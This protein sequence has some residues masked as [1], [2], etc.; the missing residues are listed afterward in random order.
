[1][2]HGV[3]EALTYRGRGVRRAAPLQ[4]L[5]LVFGT[6]FGGFGNLDQALP[7]VGAAVQDD[8]FHPFPQHGLH[9]VV[10][11]HHASVDDT[12]VHAR[13][14][15]VV[16]KH[17]V[18]GLA[19][20]VVAAKRKAHVRHATRHLGT[21]QVLLDPARGLDEVHRV[22]VVLLNAS[23]DGEDV[24]VE[25]DVFSREPHFVNQNAVSALADGDLALVGVGLALLVKG[26][27]HGGGTVAAHQSGLALELG[28]AFFHADGVDD[29]FALHTA[30]AGLDD[31]PLAGV[32][33]DRNPRNIWLGRYQIEKAHHGGLAVEHGL[34][35]VDVDDLGAVFHLLARHGQCL[36]KVPVQDHAGERLGTGHI[37]ALTDVDKQRIAIDEDRL[38]TGQHHGGDGNRGHTSHL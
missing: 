14:N 1:M 38:Q 19:H 25:D 23:S 12:H 33:H 24:G 5:T 30:Q 18:N 7:R 3:G 20:R 17:G 36:L 34:I 27:D 28:H 37:G 6:A 32:D 26:H 29:T 15:R 10:D 31:A 2:H 16:Q 13:G 22:V 9:I 35:H 21:R 11:P 4:F 8:I